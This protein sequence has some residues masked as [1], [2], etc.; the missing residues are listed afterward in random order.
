MIIGGGGGVGVGIGG[1]VRW[2]IEGSLI[3]FIGKG[4]L[5]TQVRSRAPQ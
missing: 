2:R 5:Q 1:K 4:P 3:L